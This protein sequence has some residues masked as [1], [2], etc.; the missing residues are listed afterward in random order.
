MPPTGM[1]ASGG[2]REAGH[3]S[4]Q[5]G[6]GTTRQDCQRVRVVIRGA[7]QGVGFR[8][9]VY[10]VARQLELLGSVSNSPLGVVIE[11]Q[12]SLVRLQDLLTRVVEEA[13][14]LAVIH[15]M[16]TTWLDPEP[17]LQS[18]RIVESTTDE[19]P[20]ALILPDI[21]TCD[22]CRTELLDVDDRRY[23]YPFTNCTHCGPRFTIVQSLPYDRQRTTMAPFH[24]CRRCQEEY[25]SPEDRR[26]HAQ[27]N[28]CP[29]CGPQLRWLD[30][31]RSD[32]RRD[33]ALQAAVSLLDAGGI[34]AVRGLGGFHLFVDATDDVA[35]A[36]LRQRKHRE[37]KPLALM[38][39]DL[40]VARDLC[41]MSDIEQRLLSSPQ[42]PIVLLQKRDTPR[43]RVAPKVAPDQPNLG[44]MLPYTPLHW[45]LL[46]DV[47]RPLVATSGNLAD[48]PICITPA[49]A[50][51]RLGG[52]ADGFLLHDR[53]ILRP[54]DDSVTRVVAGREMVMR[55]SRGY[56][57]MPVQLPAP[58]PPT[59]AAGAQQKNVVA[60]A[61][62]TMAFLSQHVGDLG[63][64]PAAKAWRSAG[65]S[66]S[67]LYHIDAPEPVCDL[68]P[69][70]DAT[71]MSRQINPR[72]R[73]VQHHHAHVL[74]CMADND[75]RDVPVLGVA[76]DGT[77]L[78]TDGTIWGGEF[79][80]IDPT[81]QMTR[82]GHLR[83]FRLPGGDTAAREPR[84]CAAGLLVARYGPA[85]LARTDLPPLASIESSRLALLETMITTGS[86]SPLTSSAGRLFDGL[87]SLLDLKQVS[88]H[89]GQAA[90]LL[91]AAATQADDSPG[92]T[93][94]KMLLRPAHAGDTLILDWGP[95]L[96]ATLADRRH[97]VEAAVIAR[98]IHM[99]LAAGI[100]AMAVRLG[101]DRVVLTGGCFQNALLTTETIRRLE[102]AG[103]HPY[104]HQRIPPNDGGIALGQLCAAALQVTNIQTSPEAPH[105]PGHPR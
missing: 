46:H 60:I 2:D 55:R 38:V 69:D 34:V 65:D 44:L 59:L 57:P 84:L 17:D 63:S 4:G 81:G 86:H 30:G 96:D 98:R 67:R 48:E 45:L 82:A 101:Q 42:A 8:P 51:Q 31:T 74:S 16:E 58:L 72:A 78:G 71:R 70:Y 39:P 76:W 6:E 43:L 32:L 105:V 26:F 85:I 28:A 64:V 66:L 33:Q 94:Y 61:D 56:A 10:R 95:L 5:S 68:H 7:V 50:Q 90:M 37:E 100:A 80:A 11:A 79:L 14:S 99:G 104:W 87:A 88:G 18:F 89:E 35:I 92:A 91:E 20:Q 49:E 83:P 93:A 15:G 77:G 53:P 13:P 52:I 97:G 12:G 102:R 73:T 75:L 19:S 21:A 47:G 62:G 22:A 41:Q 3:L 25:D 36:R 54:V 24:M 9:H 1:A 27:P 29:D 103:H 40:A 23:R